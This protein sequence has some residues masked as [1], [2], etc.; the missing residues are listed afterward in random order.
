MKPGRAPSSSSSPTSTCVLCRRD[1]C[2]FHK[3]AEDTGEKVCEINHHTYVGNH[4]TV[5]NIFRSVEEREISL[6][7]AD[8]GGKYSA[9]LDCVFR[10]GDEGTGF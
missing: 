8:S 1:F 5:K 2:E 7:S 9:D 3:A 6:L 4:G 10:A